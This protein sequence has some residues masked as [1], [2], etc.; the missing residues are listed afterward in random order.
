VL[1]P[2][3]RNEY[4]YFVVKGSMLGRWNACNISGPPYL[5]TIRSRTGIL[6]LR[7]D[8]ISL[9]YLLASVVFCKVVA[10]SASGAES[11]LEM[12]PR[13]SS[14]ARTVWTKSFWTIELE[15]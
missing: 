5:R 3:A 11:R 15:L 6:S 10:M 4:V 13:V 12:T 8:L 9:E 7:T 1:N 2:V 14:T